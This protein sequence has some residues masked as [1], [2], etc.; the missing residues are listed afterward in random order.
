M[1]LFILKK[2]EKVENYRTQ[3]LNYVLRN[4]T[5]L[6][7]YIMKFKNNNFPRLIQQSTHILAFPFH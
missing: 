1:G 5:C 3:G 7:K 2:K 4:E 6:L